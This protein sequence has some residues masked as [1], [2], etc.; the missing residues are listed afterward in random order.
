MRILVDENLPVRFF[1]ELLGK[2]DTRTVRD[3]GWSGIKNGELL[4][5]VE[6]EFD[7]FV[8]ADKNIR[9]QQHLS[10]RSFAIVEIFTNR[11]PNLR[12]WSDEILDGIRSSSGN[13][14]VRIGPEQDGADNVASR[15]T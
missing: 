14:Y 11:L 4:K 13:D 12:E 1:S 10:D 7:V 9:Y 3:L 15:R 6:G 8:T 2:F 5:R